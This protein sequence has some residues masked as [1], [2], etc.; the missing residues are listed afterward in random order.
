[1]GLQVS[2]A[3]GNISRTDCSVQ[4][5]SDLYCHS[6]SR[7]QHIAYYE[8]ISAY[9]KLT[10]WEDETGQVAAVGVEQLLMTPESCS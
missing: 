2:S 7:K 8:M 9:Y 1:M 3:S 5:S 4:F 6:E 10:N